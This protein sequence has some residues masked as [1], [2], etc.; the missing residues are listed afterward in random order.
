MVH[1]TGPIDDGTAAWSRTDEW[2]L[3]AR[4]L[5]AI[6]AFH[7]ARAI[8]AWASAARARSRL[9]REQDARQLEVLRRKHQAVIERAHEQLRS[10]GVRQ[11]PPVPHRRVVV[12]D[13][14]A[15]DGLVG[16]LEGHGMRVVARV[17]NGADAVG[18]ALVEQPEILL[19]SEPLDM[20]PAEDVVRDVRGYSPETGVVALATTPER[21]RACTQAGASLVLI[22]AVATDELV[23]Q[24]LRM[25][26][27]RP[28]G[29]T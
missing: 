17:G 6:S 5:R 21:A 22:G 25:G 29:R 4:Q 27:Q 15:D 24:L 10:S 9:V 19:V 14:R 18:I 16:R 28:P 23:G 11:A 1:S 20:L 7:H 8:A 13:R 3:A 12:A 26:A 2:D